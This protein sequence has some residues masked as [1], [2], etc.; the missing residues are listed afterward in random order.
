LRPP[1]RFGARDLRLEPAP[2]QTVLP[3]KPWKIAPRMGVQARLRQAISAQ[4][5]PNRSVQMIGFAWEFM[6]AQ[7]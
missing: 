6:F 1:L 4:R 3:D 2:T 5:A 7:K